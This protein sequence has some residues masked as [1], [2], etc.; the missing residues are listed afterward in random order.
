M[1]FTYTLVYLFL[2]Y[3][4]TTTVVSLGSHFSPP[5]LLLFLSLDILRSCTQFIGTAIEF[6]LF[7]ASPT[8]SRAL[9]SCAS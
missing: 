8:P 1:L 4:F 7:L 6:S 5:L 3:K 9:G 2:L